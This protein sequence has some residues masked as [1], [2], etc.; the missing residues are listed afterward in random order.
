MSPFLFQKVSK[1]WK[2][3]KKKRGERGKLSALDRYLTPCEN[4]TPVISLGLILEENV[5]NY[6]DMKQG[7]H[8][9]REW[10]PPPPSLPP[11]TFIFDTH[12]ECDSWQ[13]WNFYLE[14]N[15]VR[16]KK[17]AQNARGFNV[18]VILIKSENSK[19][20]RFLYR[21]VKLFSCASYV[22]ERN[23]LFILVL[24]WLHFSPRHS[25]WNINSHQSYVP[26]P[27]SIAATLNA[28]T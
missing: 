14:K 20:F 27:P 9:F 28:R 7:V 4:F 22:D 23:R 21:H 6:R 24:F 12:F 25:S 11:A 18:N 19:R 5:I 8:T 10:T 16:L 15:I 13:K 26:L 17:G 1:T 2:K 3:K